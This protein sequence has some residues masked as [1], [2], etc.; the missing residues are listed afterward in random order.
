MTSGVWTQYLH[1][2]FIYCEF[3]ITKRSVR[4]IQ[5]DSIGNESMLKIK[6][7]SESV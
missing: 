2:I 1:K 7:Q 4:T 5:V 3:D 6:N